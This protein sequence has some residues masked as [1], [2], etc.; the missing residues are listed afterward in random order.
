MASRARTLSPADEARHR[1]QRDL[2]DGAQQRVVTL[3]VKLKM[4]AAS[5]VA[6]VSGL[7]ADV[8][9]LVSDVEDAL[10]ELRDIS[11]R[12]VLSV[13]RWC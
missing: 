6:R 13:R 8:L 5:D 3:A 1:I 10:S 7:D 9:D 4:L 12:E 11:R 2:D